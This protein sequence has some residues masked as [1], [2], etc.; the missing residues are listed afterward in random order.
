MCHTDNG[1]EFTSHMLVSMLREWSPNCVTITG[2][3][4]TPRHQGSIE[5][6]N[7]D[8]K[9]L[10]ETIIASKLDANPDCGANWVNTIPDVT[11]TINSRT[12]R[13][14][15]SPYFH[16]FGMEY[17]AHIQ[18]TAASVVDLHPCTT[19]SEVIAGQQNPALETQSKNNYEINTSAS[20]LSTSLSSSS[21]SSSLSLSSSSLSS[22][23]SSSPSSSTSRCT[24]DN[25]HVQSNCDLQQL[26]SSRI[27]LMVS[28][29]L[30][31]CSTTNNDDTEPS[32]PCIMSM[33]NSTFSLLDIGSQQHYMQM[34]D[35]TSKEFF[36][37]GDVTTFSHL[38]TQKYMEEKGLSGDV[39]FV[40]S[41]PIRRY[42]DVSTHTIIPDSMR[43]LVSVFI[44]NSHF[45]TAVFHLETKVV[46]IWDGLRSNIG[47]WHQQ[48]CAVML[49][50]NIARSSHSDEAPSSFLNNAGWRIQFGSSRRQS[51]GYTCGAIAMHNF[52]QIF[53]GC[54]RH[55]VSNQ[56]LRRIVTCRL[57]E[58]IHHFDDRI[59][60]MRRTRDVV[61]ESL[62]TNLFFEHNVTGD[63][64]S[65]NIR[66]LL[67]PFD[68]TAPTHDNTNEIHS[69]GDWQCGVCLENGVED[70][71]ILLCQH[72]FHKSCI[73]RWRSQGLEGNQTNC[74]VCRQ[75]LVPA[76][77][78]LSEFVC[79]LPMFC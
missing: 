35:E 60:F 56:Q 63:T 75:M 44:E 32:D 20:S 51:D 21:S 53:F 25:Q 15:L 59:T 13:N 24:Y 79:V 6:Q 57:L 7:G 65:Q 37:Y 66:N 54:R 74:P 9:R 14:G 12:D 58:L 41:T 73:M 3:A 67:S 34:M 76:T 39:F 64:I 28:Y 48:I 1:A 33:H 8:F 2:A 31:F 4:R 30:L 61:F 42:T 11:K 19:T 18:Q 10:S 47:T 46:E 72:A 52:E 23:S 17:N 78:N 43:R 38:I 22:S 27:V 55:G 70:I 71:R 5:R 16:V 62:H 49:R 40:Q 69:D 77:Y 50:C 26:L 36:R 68:T 45:V 29:H